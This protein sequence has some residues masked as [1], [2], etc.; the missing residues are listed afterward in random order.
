MPDI[1][2]HPMSPSYIYW[3]ENER[4]IKDRIQV[5]FELDYDLK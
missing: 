4:T 5:S 1:K 3:K 2:E